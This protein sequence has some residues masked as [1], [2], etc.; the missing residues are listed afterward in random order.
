MERNCRVCLYRHIDALRRRWQ[1]RDPFDPFLV[2]ET[3][4]GVELY[5]TAFAS[6]GLHG[7]IVTTHDKSGAKIVLDARRS[8]EEQMFDLSHELVHFAL[9][10]PTDTVHGYSPFMEWQANEGAA[11]L[12]L[13]R[14]LLLHVLAETRERIRTPYDASRLIQSLAR[15][16]GIRE[17]VV[18][19]RVWSLRQYAAL[20]LDGA[21]PDS[22]PLLPQRKYAPITGGP[23]S[24][25][26]P[27]G[28]IPPSVVQ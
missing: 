2:A 19:W 14:A 26:F 12:L 4:P 7:F 23:V 6:A 8:A 20:T 11:E 27:S 3:L 17:S 5:E 25:F 18:R 21:A 22:L 15:R 10:P 28:H 1:I 9:H 16:Q 13:P 24:W